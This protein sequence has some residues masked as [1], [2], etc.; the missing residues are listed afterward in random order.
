MPGGNDFGFVANDL[1][2]VVFEGWPDLRAFRDAALGA[3]ALQS[4]VS[5][6]GSTVFGIFRESAEVRHAIAI[7]RDR[8]GAWDLRP[9][10]TIREGV[11]VR[12]RTD[13][14]G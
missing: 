13:D 7:L 14:E 5:G 1:E 12:I 2:E 3:G 11:S 9:C 8:F 4:A 10:R 6:S